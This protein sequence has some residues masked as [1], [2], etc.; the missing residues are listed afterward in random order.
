MALLRSHGAW[1]SGDGVEARPGRDGGGPCWLLR[2]AAV[3]ARLF[4]HFCPKTSNRDS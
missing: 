4:A 1:E 2:I 3:V